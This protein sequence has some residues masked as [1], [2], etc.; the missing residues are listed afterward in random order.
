MNDNP[1]Y[2]MMVGVPASGKSTFISDYIKDDFI[3]Y[4][5]DHE[6]DHY[7]YSLGLTYDQIFNDWIKTATEEAESWRNYAFK[8]DI[9]VVDDHTNLNVKTRAKRLELVPNHYTKI[10]F[11]FDIPEKEEHIRRLNSRPGKTI[12]SDVLNG[13]I[14]SYVKPT[15]AEGFSYIVEI[16]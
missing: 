3:T 8:Y 2:M 14:R 11:V 12:P 4:S 7:A 10:A 13:M 1:L 6:L 5:S 15:Y 9:D 16:T